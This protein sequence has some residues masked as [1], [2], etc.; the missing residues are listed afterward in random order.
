M[1]TVPSVRRTGPRRMT[2]PGV[3]RLTAAA[4]GLPLAVAA[5]L[6]AS[7]LA[8]QAT[9]EAA[10]FR[11]VT[12]QATG[13]LRLGAT[14]GNGDAPIIDI[15][16][17]ILALASAGAPEIQNLGYV[18][19]DTRSL[20][21]IGDT[22]VAS[23]KTVH[24]AALK[25]KA[26]GRWTDPGGERRVFYP[27]TAVR[28]RAPVPNPQKM[29]GMAGN[30][31]REGESELTA[32]TPET[33]A[34]V[35]TAG[36]QARP[37]GGLG[38]TPDRRLPSFFL[39]SVS[40]IV[41]QDDDI[42]M[43]DL[44]ADGYPNSHEAEL[45]VIIGKRA[46]NVPEA[47]AF[48]YVFGYTI[49]NDVSGRTLRSGASS[50]EGSSMTKG[51]DTFAPLG[52]Y[53]TLKADVP[54]PHNLAIE[55]KLNGKVFPMPNAHTRYMRHRIPAAISYLSRIMTLQ[56]GDILATGVPAPTAPLNA[57]DTVE[58]TIERLGTLRNRV[59]MKPSGSDE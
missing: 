43:T 15:H 36:T 54:D 12:F 49:H 31:R 46:R 30:Y 22:A 48:D 10:I 40:A 14:Q 7:S 58:I 35:P 33:A 1:S 41:G 38:R 11:L 39:K 8:R 45:A 25:L 9:G 18:P 4:V 3:A 23:V 37:G 34:A 59:V 5:I 6:P 47:R 21:E 51:M 55:T 24:Q 52:P 26:G 27:P 17:A 16:N 32:A 53:L 2:F 44:L 29:F 56:P 13:D 28:L 19:A 50:S 20:I 42:V 57:G